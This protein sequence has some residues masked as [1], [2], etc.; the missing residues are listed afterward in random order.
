MGQNGVLFFAGRLKGRD[1]NFD[2]TRLK[3][4]ATTLNEQSAQA[5]LQQYCGPTLNSTFQ[6]LQTALAPPAS[7][8]P[9]AGKPGAPAPRKP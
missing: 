3:S 7:Q 9:P 4:I 8:S 5:D 2:F 1:P 6:Q